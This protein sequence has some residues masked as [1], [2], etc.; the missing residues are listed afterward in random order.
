MSTRGGGSDRGGLAPGCQNMSVHA[1]GWPGTGCLTKWIRRGPLQGGGD[2]GSLAW[3]SEPEWIEE[4]ALM[5]NGS[6][7]GPAWGAGA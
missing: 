2:G 7:S 5:S 1:G 4:S 6:C 3:G